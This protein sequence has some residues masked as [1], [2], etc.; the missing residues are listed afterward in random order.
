MA[1]KYRTRH[2]HNAT[3]SQILLGLQVKILLTS[4]GSELSSRRESSALTAHC[5]LT[6]ERRTEFLRYFLSRAMGPTDGCLGAWAGGRRPLAPGTR[7]VYLLRKRPAGE[8]F[9]A[10]GCRPRGGEGLL[11]RPGCPSAAGTPAQNTR[12]TPPPPSPCAAAQ[13]P[14]R[15]VG[16]GKE[17]PGDWPRVTCMGG[18]RLAIGGWP[19]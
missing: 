18:E 7:G 2:Q 5:E 17:A 19:R 8:P 4:A 13:A 10:A 11:P 1:H 15:L 3:T 6:F 9:A 12:R 16:P 14:P